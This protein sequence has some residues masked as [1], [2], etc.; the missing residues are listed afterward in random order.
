MKYT[1]Y[2]YADDIESGKIKSCE[3][4]KLAVKR[5]KEW[6]NRD[7]IYFDEEDVQQKIRIVAKLKHTTGSHNGKPFI[8]LPYQQFIIAAIFGIKDRKTN[9]IW[10]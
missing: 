6:F 3:A 2:Q 1:Y 7:D 10:I 9:T 4:I 5:F 8:L